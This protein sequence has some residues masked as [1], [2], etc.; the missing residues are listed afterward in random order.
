MALAPRLDV[1]LVPD[2][3]CPA[4]Q[5]QGIPVMWISRPLVL[6][7]GRH[8]RGGLLVNT[9]SLGILKASVGDM[10][11]I[12]EKKPR[13][14]HARPCT[15]VTCR[16]TRDMDVQCKPGT[17]TCNQG[18]IDPPA[19][20]CDQRGDLGRPGTWGPQARV[21]PLLVLQ[22]GGH[23]GRCTAWGLFWAQR[24]CTFSLFWPYPPLTCPYQ[25]G[26]LVGGGQFSVLALS[27]SPSAR[28]QRMGL[29]PG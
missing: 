1:R 10:G 14:Q 26:H 11:D 13:P 23:L 19:D 12:K 20:M 9:A 29:F 24:P 4:P 6:L 28:V 2:V 3:G 17:V 18:P 22:L 16:V 25:D 7:G 27:H 15:W 5:P 21:C 8:L